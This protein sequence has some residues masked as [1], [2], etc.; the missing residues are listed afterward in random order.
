MADKKDATMTITAEGPSYTLINP[1]TKETIVF[2]T[3]T[4]VKK[5]P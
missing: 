5:V 4:F 3:D 1:R 2:D